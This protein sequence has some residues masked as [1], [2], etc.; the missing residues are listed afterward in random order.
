MDLL[1]TAV[2]ASVVA[3][4]GLMLSLQMR[5]RLDS[6]EREMDR[7]FEQTDRRFE[8]IDRRFEQIERRLDRFEASIDAIRSDLTRVALAVGASPRR[9][10]G[11]G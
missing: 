4:V 10:A 5:G 7:R 3:A 6:I 11:A 2:G 1:N 9:D 8:Q